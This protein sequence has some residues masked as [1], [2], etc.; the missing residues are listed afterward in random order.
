M[1][2][3]LEHINK[4]VRPALRK[5]ATAEKALTAANETGDQKT[6]DEA[7][8][9]VLLAARQAVDVLH[10][11]SDFVLKE[12]VQQ[13][14]TFQDVA[15]VR[16]AVREHCV[17]LRVAAVD[18]RRTIALWNDRPLGCGGNVQPFSACA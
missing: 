15:Q 9:E 2:A 10:H 12:P 16:A 6:I 8:Q 7:R 3:I 1:K 11:L 4:I 5:Y 14:P 18:R 17:F 13:L